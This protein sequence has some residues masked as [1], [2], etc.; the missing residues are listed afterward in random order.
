VLLSAKPNLTPAEIAQSF[1]QT[2]RDVRRG[3]SSPIFDQPAEIG[4]DVATGFGLIDVSAALVF[5][6][7]NFS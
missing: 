6:Q 4:Q 5:A 7:Q 2:A 3:R 1:S